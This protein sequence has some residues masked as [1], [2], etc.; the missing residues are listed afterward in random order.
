MKEKWAGIA[1][2]A[3]AV[4]A[5]VCC[6]GPLV[7]AGL[8]LGSL[9]FAAGFVKYR[10]L[11]IAM[12]FALVGLAFYLTYRKREVRCADGSC[13]VTSAGRG[14]KILLWF[15]TVTAVGLASSHLW[16]GAF[17]SK[18]AVA[19]EGKRI[20]LHITGM[21]CPACAVGVEQALKQVRGVRAADV[22]FD[23]SQAHVV[24]EAGNVDSRELIEAVEKTGYKAS[25][26]P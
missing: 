12:T 17:A 16:I 3:S 25:L 11:F 13:V 1:A 5:S 4:L 18:A 23:K 26:Q 14:A 9:G 21:H 20:Y 10:S 6:I 2:V 24:V 19:S 8:G 7:L 22:D 15:V